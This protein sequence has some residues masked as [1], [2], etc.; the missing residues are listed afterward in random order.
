[1]IMKPYRDEKTSRKIHAYTH[2]T[3]WL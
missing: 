3:L 1:L 2:K